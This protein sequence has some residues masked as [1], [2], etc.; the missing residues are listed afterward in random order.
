MTLAGGPRQ[1]T[2]RA[3]TE[4]GGD[5]GYDDIQ[6]GAAVTVYDATGA[7]V[8]TGSLGVPEYDDSNYVTR[9]CRFPISVAGVPKGSAIF[10]VEVTHRGKISIKAADAEAGKFAATLG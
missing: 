1:V 8:G 2:S 6:A 5:N 3:D 7:A 4:C 9:T 10:Q